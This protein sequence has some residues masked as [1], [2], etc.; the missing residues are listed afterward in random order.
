MIYLTRTRLIHESERAIEACAL[1]GEPVPQRVC[2]QLLAQ[3]PRYSRWHN[4]L[5]NRMG[6]VAN[7]RVRPRQVLALRA[8]ALEQ[9]HRAALVRYL[10]D[11][12]VV[13]RAREQTLRDFHGVIDSREAA[14]AEH[15]DYL[16]A[17]TNH[18]C[19]A[20]LLDL[21]DDAPGTELLGEYERAYG[22]FFR[23]FC[24]Q[25]RAAY[26]REPY[27]LESLLPEVRATAAF[28]R[29]QILNGDVSRKPAHRTSG[30]ALAIQAINL[31]RLRGKG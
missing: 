13:G 31:L 24:E 1:A 18:V 28:V 30:G 22:Q 3:P 7:A 29:R 25:S 6:I 26:R 20:E 23:L 16:L 14:L 11:Y 8:F 17:T 2:A 9:V 4:G 21:A 19:A 10:R 15:R 5:E 12:R 27:L